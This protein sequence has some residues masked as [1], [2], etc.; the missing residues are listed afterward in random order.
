[1]KRTH[2]TQRIQNRSE[3]GQSLVELAMSVTFLLILVAGVV[4]LG[5][6]FFAFTALREAAQEGATFAALAPYDMVGIETRARH[7]SDKPIDLTD[8]SSVQ[9]TTEFSG[10]RCSGVHLV[11]GQPI[12][13]SAT[14]TVAYNFDLTMPLIGAFIGSQHFP[15]KATVTDTILRLQCPGS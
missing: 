15:L 11:N 12:S 1:M 6:M 14:V 8:A 10:D 4:D 9:V 13:N 3:K 2:R 5:R 7:S